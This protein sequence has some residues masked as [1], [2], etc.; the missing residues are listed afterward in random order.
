MNSRMEVHDSSEGELRLLPLILQKIIITIT[1]TTR[2]RMRSKRDES[3]ISSL[4]QRS[5]S[6][7]RSDIRRLM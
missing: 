1:I 2:H 6:S 4:D 3:D 5:R 7:E